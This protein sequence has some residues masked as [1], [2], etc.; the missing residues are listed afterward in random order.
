MDDLTR[1]IER[2]MALPTSRE[3]KYALYALFARRGPEILQAVK[4]AERYYELL[5][6]VASKWPN[7]SRHETALRYIVE[8]ESSSRS[9]PVSQREK[10]IDA[11]IASG[12]GE[13]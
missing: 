2:V 10:A 13:V 9:G 3:V 4:D 7:E 11:A 1:E 12:K 8:R 6:A 5:Y